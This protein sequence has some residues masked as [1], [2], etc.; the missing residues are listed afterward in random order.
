[1]AYNHANSAG[2]QSKSRRSVTNIGMR[3]TFN[4]SALTLETHLL[5]APAEFEAKRI[6]IRFWRR[7]RNEKKFA[8]AEELK[9]QIARDIAAAHQFFARLRRFRSLRLGSQAIPAS[10][11]VT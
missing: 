1:M 8:G 9:T 3:P 2:R 7:L 5:D 10:P 6:E 4:G 11:G